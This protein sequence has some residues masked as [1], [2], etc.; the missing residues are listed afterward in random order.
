MRH[1]GWVS[2]EFGYVFNVPDPQLPTLITVPLDLPNCSA[3]E[4]IAVRLNVLTGVAG[5]VR[6]GVAQPVSPSPT[7]RSGRETSLGSGRELS[8]G[9]QSEPSEFL[10]GFGINQSTIIKGNFMDAR[11]SWCGDET[12]SE[13]TSRPLPNDLSRGEGRAQPAPVCQSPYWRLRGAARA[14][15]HVVGNDASLFSLKLLCEV[16]GLLNVNGRGGL[17]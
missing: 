14:V 7:L 2:A 15:F 12:E 3:G 9:P 17:L 11:A 4:S 16:D 1:D 5:S 13:E 10:D 6:V 8:F